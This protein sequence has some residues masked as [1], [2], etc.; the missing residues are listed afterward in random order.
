M[1]VIKVENVTK[2][3]PMYDKPSDRLKEALSPFHKSYHHDFFALENI[4]FHIGAGETVG[5]V[6]TNG[7]GKSTILK[8]I[9]GVL[10][11]TQGTSE[12]NGKIS[13]LLELGAGF[14]MDYTGLENLYMNGTM[15][16]YTRDEMEERIP[17]ILEFA[18]IG[19]FI[20]Q[21]VKTYSSGMFVRLAFALAISVEPE[22][23]IV[24]E[25]LSVGDAFF[26]AKCF[27][28]LEEI[29]KSGTT[30]LFVSHDMMSVKKLCKRAIWLEQGVV[31]M[32]GDAGDVCEAYLSMQIAEN[33][34][35]KFKAVQS[36]QQTKHMVQAEVSKETVAYKRADYSRCKNIS[37]TGAADMLSFYI[38][39]RD[40]NDVNVI[41]TQK[42]YTFGIVAKFNEEVKN[43]LFG[44]ELENAKGTKLISINNYMTDRV[45]KVAEKG[46]IYEVEFEV[47]I[48]RICSGEYL[49]TPAI[50]EGI[51][52]NHLVH[53]R[54][55]NYM[56]ITV[57]NEGGYN[58]A[59]IELDA[60]SKLIER[61]ENQITLYD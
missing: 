21:P 59:L 14:N 53:C 29:K 24:D 6:G 27:H 20:N 17:G 43:A 37:Q 39:D 28:K 54:L 50:A 8:I 7:S 35:R 42:M 26:Q 19:D 25:A 30:I 33:N 32:D 40:G 12:T 49:I 57:E 52:D 41:K 47:E 5:I 61:Q 55:H 48:P 18:D 2:V 11:P 16:G 46:H 44:F 9:T 51:Q 13:A 22:I 1:D 34:R 60:H 45:L 58:F 36:V 23:L 56:M 10:N 31:R 3:Y 4:S 38:R 15:M